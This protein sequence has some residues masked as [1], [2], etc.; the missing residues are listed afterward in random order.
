M[1]LM[2]CSW[3]S[4]MWVV[5]E[6]VL[7]R[8]SRLIIG[9][10]A[11][12]GSLMTGFYRSYSGHL[13]PGSCCHLSVAWRMAGGLWDH[14]VDIRR[15][16]WSLNLARNEFHS[17]N[18]GEPPPAAAARLRKTWLLMRHKESTDP[19]DKIYG[20]L[21]LVPGVE[22]YPDYTVDT[23]EAFARATEFLIN[24]E[25]SLMAL[26]GPRVR[27]A[28]LPSWVPDLIGGADDRFFQN[29]IRRTNPSERFTASKGLRIGHIRK[30]GH[31]HLSGHRVDTINVVSAPIPDRQEAEGLMRWESQ[32]GINSLE[33]SGTGHYPAGGS[34]GDAFWRTIIRDMITSVREPESV[35]QA[36]PEDASCYRVFRQWIT[37]S[38]SAERPRIA[39]C[40]PGF[41]HFR[42][43]FFVATQQQSFFTTARGFF[44]LAL[45]LKPDDEVWILAGGTV[46]FLLRPCS[47]SSSVEGQYILVGDCFVYGMMYGE[48]VESEQ[49]LSRVCLI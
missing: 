20:V 11:V 13:P 6:F 23:A 3:W 2:E 31:L 22:F 1:R 43:S 26:V 10:A 36:A 48:Q 47:S 16:V 42:K 18:R 39:S 45:E 37:E 7:A 33:T 46:P 32:S 41:E 24:S 44:G 27:L 30:W 35:R 4:R 15:T 49:P 38:D 34:Q 14:M 8:E 21:G 17:R 40:H 5:Q 28:G 29:T 12:P 19:R 9:N 25:Q